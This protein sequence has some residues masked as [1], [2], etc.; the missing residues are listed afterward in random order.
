MSKL[1][2]VR[3][4]LDRKLVALNGDNSNVLDLQKAYGF[5][6]VAGNEWN[7]LL[8]TAWLTAVSKILPQHTFELYDEGEFL[9]H[10]L[11]IKN[12]KARSIR[13]S[14]WKDVGEFCLL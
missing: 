5:T 3:E 13:G 10:R 6:K 4:L 1:K 11:V 12:G 7:A 2:I 8:V 14:V 9:T